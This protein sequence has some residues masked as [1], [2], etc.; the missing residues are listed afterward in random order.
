[1]KSIQN[2]IEQYRNAT[3]L[4]GQALQDGDKKTA[5]KQYT[6]IKKLYQ[7]IQ[8][9]KME[10]QILSELLSDESIH[11]L[12][13]AAAHCLSLNIHVDKSVHILESLADRKDI[14]IAR[15]NAEMILESW[16]TKGALKF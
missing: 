10:D 14:G 15:L 8:K 1:M 16:K 5:N 11:V 7:L 6:V 13:W 3:N 12:A 2:I 9:E 4:H